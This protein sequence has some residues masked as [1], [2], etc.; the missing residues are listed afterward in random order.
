MGN[1]RQ[2]IVAKKRVYGSTNIAAMASVARL[3]NHA[4][5]FDKMLVLIP[6][7]FYYPPD[8]A[9][10]GS[11]LKA[12]TQKKRK[13]EQM[14]TQQRKEGSK[15]GKRAKLLPG[16][17]KSILDIQFEKFSA[18]DQE[19]QQEV[20]EA[21]EAVAEV[22]VS[23]LR[24]KLQGQL[25]ELSA[26]RKAKMVDIEL[27]RLE[28]KEKKKEEKEREAKEGPRPDSKLSAGRVELD[29]DDDDDG[30]E[31]ASDED[32]GDGVQFDLVNPKGAAAIEAKGGAPPK[33]K[34]VSKHKALQQALNEEQQLAAVEDPEEK[35][36][37]LA[38]KSWD[39][40]L[41]KAQGR[42]VMSSTKVLQKSIN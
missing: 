26:K 23:D 42:K 11:N 18:K 3:R 17:S 16:T 29:D 1:E 19:K 8:S 39:D 9:D 31:D 10:G 35:K 40:A 4:E 12:V 24:L 30:D 34:G 14:S 25:K 36:K 15:K 37:L 33:R 7:K 41:T 13:Q 22:S 38:R 21:S 20:G 5:A 28:R 27:R 2:V 6:A 32:V